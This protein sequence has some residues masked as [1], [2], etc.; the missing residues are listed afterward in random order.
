MATHLLTMQITN[1]LTGIPAVQVS[2]SLSAAD[3]ATMDQLIADD[4]AIVNMNLGPGG[5]T[6]QAGIIFT[7]DIT[8]TSLSGLTN[9][10]ISTPATATIASIRPGQWIYGPNIP[11]GQQVLSASGTTIHMTGTDTPT[12]VATANTYFV[13]GRRLAGSFSTNGEL[14]IPNRGVLKIFPGDY[15]AVDNSGWPILLSA[16]S[17]A[18]PKSSWTFT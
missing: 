16:E 17:I 15:V 2:A 6:I 9:V 10:T 3:V 12:A 14:F 13:T 18:F 4:Q 11:T 7:A 1:N 8:T 5:T